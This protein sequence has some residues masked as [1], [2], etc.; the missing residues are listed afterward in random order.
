MIEPLTIIHG[1]PQGSIFRPT[2]FSLYSNDL[3][4]VIKLRN[5]ESYAYYT[6]IYFSFATNDID[7]RLRQVAEDIQHVAEWC[8]TNLICCI[9]DMQ[10]FLEFRF[11]FCLS[12]DQMFGQ[13]AMVSK[14]ERSTSLDMLSSWSK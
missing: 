6:K 7:S 5:I 11:F 8:C 10:H 13:C 3:P 12:R 9:D 1:V 2:L 4:E 14:A